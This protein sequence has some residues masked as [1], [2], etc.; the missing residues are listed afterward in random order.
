M[1]CLRQLRVLLLT[2]VCAISV[3]DTAPCQ[4]N[5]S[6][7]DNAD[8]KGLNIDAVLGWDKL[9][10][11]NAPVCVSFLLQNYSD[12]IIEGQLTLSDPVN[13]R[14]IVIGEVTLAPNSTRRFA[15]IRSFDDEWFECFATLKSGRKVLWRREL[16]LG[17]GAYQQDSNYAIFVDESG[18][19]PLFAQPQAKAV[20][21]GQAINQYI[22]EEQPLSEPGGRPVRNLSV[23]SWQLPDHPGPLMA[24]QA[25][26][27]PEATDDRL[28]T[29]KQWRA[30]ANWL[31][32]G[33][34]IFVH[35]DSKGVIEELTKAAPLSYEASDNNGEF[36]TTPIGL[37]AI[38]QYQQ[39][40]MGSAGQGVRDSMRTTI[41]ALTK[42]QLLML[43]DSIQYLHD[44]VGQAQIT[45]VYVIGFFGIFTFLSGVMTLLLSRLSQRKMA[46]YV[47]S[48]L[49]GASVSAA[50]L[51]AWLR[52][53]PGDLTWVSV[54]QTGAGGAVQMARVDVQSAGSRSNLVAVKGD[55]PDLQFVRQQRRDSFY[56]LPRR[57]TMPFNWQ[58]N[59]LAGEADIYQINVP[60]NAWGRRKMFAT[61]FVN[62]LPQLDFSLDFKPASDSD[63]TQ[64]GSNTIVQP[65]GEF[66]LSITNSLPARAGTDAWLVIGAT[67]WSTDDF[68]GSY[69]Y[70]GQPVTNSAR[71]VDIYHL[72]TV[73]LPPRGES[74]TKT[75]PASFDY[76]PY[77]DSVHL[78][79]DD[80][81]ISVAFPEIERK[82]QASAWLIT[83]L[84]SSPN[85]AI[86]EG[87]T[88]FLPQ[89]DAHILIQQIRPEDM[90]DGSLFLG[91]PPPPPATEDS[92]GASVESAQAP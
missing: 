86:D 12:Q 28:I 5:L 38:H 58:P 75:F 51:G 15:K 14:D 11:Q 20:P 45:R 39:P 31:C 82:G 77:G 34:H 2:L 24:V 48:V 19:R 74:T 66:R 32:Q 80:T 7:R 79:T 8:T 4:E 72:E 81:R 44:G 62:D 50:V 1:T 21:T 33:G 68:R 17:T 22:E 6:D 47:T 10:D 40:M 73:R 9:V 65:K 67:R 60:I 87:R 52:S 30:L 35:A 56:G 54:T 55:T 64:D 27:F 70:Y 90:A 26:I 42:P 61:G 88:E 43:A 16:P 3:S 53:S 91:N 83:N 49:V 85:L 37:G 78:Y 76:E 57:R 63:N 71:V 29:L 13:R 36:R 92:S 18:R 84:N 69:G 59:L 41:G 23:T 46:I 25:V 89:G